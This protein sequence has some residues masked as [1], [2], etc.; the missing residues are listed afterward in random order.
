MPLP[1]EKRQPG[2]RFR[3]IR[4]KLGHSQS[5]LAALLGVTQGAISQI[6]KGSTKPSFDI[7]ARLLEQTSPRELCYLLSGQ[8]VDLPS[9]NEIISSVT[10]VIRPLTTPMNEAPLDALAEDHL[11]VPLIEGKVAAGAGGFLWQQVRRLV[12]IYRPE[13]GPHRNLIATKV[14]GDSMYPTVPD[15]AIVIIDRDQR[16]PS[17]LRKHIWA[18][19]T[20]RD[21]A[22]AIKRLQI[23]KDP[24]SFLVL[25]DNFSQYP[26]ELAWTC[27]PN[28]LV[29]GQ[30]VWMWRSL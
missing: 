26:P 28:E 13:I 30:V 3:D 10:P 2:E 12:W 4:L 24:P 18:I 19:R 9:I 25:S 1:Y 21:G 23:M 29:V 11:A 22:I 8:H 5:E 7:L 14:S 20:D 15:G 17:G 6:E 16:Q 27:E